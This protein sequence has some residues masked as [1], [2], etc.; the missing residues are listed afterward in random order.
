MVDGPRRFSFNESVQF[1]HFVHHG[2]MQVSDPHKFNL[3]ISSLG[4]VNPVHREILF[5]Q[6][7]FSFGGKIRP[8]LNLKKIKKYR[9]IV[10]F[11][12]QH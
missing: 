1:D 9:Q 12:V 3:N 5:L 2:T 11:H 8:A 4:F 6:I 7:F 10:I